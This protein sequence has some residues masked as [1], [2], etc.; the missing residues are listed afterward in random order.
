M[1]RKKTVVPT[2]WDV[3]SPT[4]VNAYNACSHEAT[5]QSPRFILYG[6]DQRYFSEDH[7]EHFSAKRRI[8]KSY[9]KP[10]TIQT[11]S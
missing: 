10:K 5:G 4:V 2:E 9:G 8:V 6:Q 7:A 1:L 3:I 11:R